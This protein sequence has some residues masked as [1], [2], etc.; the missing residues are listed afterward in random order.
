M[1]YSDNSW[2]RHI[3]EG[4]S[5]HLTDI[6]IRPSMILRNTAVPT[7]I[8]DFTFGRIKFCSVW[9]KIS[10]SPSQLGLRHSKIYPVMAPELPK[11]NAQCFKFFSPT[12]AP[13]IKQTNAKTYN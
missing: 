4:K 11:E 10:V 13:F 3:R 12:N 2:S 8:S 6:R 1:M 9:N 7:K 5:T